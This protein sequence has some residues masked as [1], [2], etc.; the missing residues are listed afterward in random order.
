MA[1]P[2]LTS[3]AQVQAFFNDFIKANKIQIQRAPHEDFWNNIDTNNG[4][5]TAYDSFVNGNVP[6]V[7]DGLGNPVKILVIG[8]S[9]A[10]NIIMALKG[11]LAGFARMPFGGPYMSDD[12][13]GQF[14]GWI[15]K[16][17]PR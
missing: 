17:C 16:K 2:A 7:Q 10:S 6:N 8:E 4:F 12:Q 11:T 3:F 9:A 14:A 1:L 13:I 15:D 5:T